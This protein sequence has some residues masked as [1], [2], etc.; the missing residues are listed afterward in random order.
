MVFTYIQ[1]SLPSLVYWSWSKSFASLAR[2]GRQ[3]CSRSFH[4]EGWFHEG[5][6]LA[7]CLVVVV[8]VFEDPRAGNPFLL[9]FVDVDEAVVLRRALR[10]VDKTSELGLLDGTHGVV[11]AYSG[12]IHLLD[13]PWVL[14]RGLAEGCAEEFGLDV[15]EFF[16]LR[17]FAE[18]HLGPV[19]FLGVCEYFSFVFSN[20]KYN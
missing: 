6:V 20:Y 2:I 19:P 10:C 4:Q 15:V 5:L 9:L 12:T 13:L 11:G 7:Q 14:G 3:D 17:S 16:I 18:R 1:V 8:D